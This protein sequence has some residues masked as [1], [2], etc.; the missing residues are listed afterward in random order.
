MFTRIVRLLRPD[1]GNGDPAAPVSEA[2]L[3]LVQ[4]LHAAIYHIVFRRRVH[5]STLKQDVPTTIGSKV[6]FFLNGARATMQDL[7]IP[8]VQN[9]ART[10]RS[11]AARHARSPT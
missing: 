4:S 9:A 10:V 1:C 5:T 2:E 3:E 11:R 6:E 8:R 7:H